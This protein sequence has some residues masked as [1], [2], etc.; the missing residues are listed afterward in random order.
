MKCSAE[1]LKASSGDLPAERRRHAGN[2]DEARTALPSLSVLIPCYNG[3]P[4]VVETVQSVVDQADDGVECVVVD[5]GST[6]GSADELERR[7]GR[8]VRVVRQP[9]GGPSAARNRA[10]AESQSELV[11][12]LD[13]DDHLAPDTL[14]ARRAA[15][16][17]NPQLELHFGQVEVVN[18]DTGE[19]ETTPRPPCDQSYMETAL[20]AHRNLPHLNGVTFRRTALERVGVFDPAFPIC[21]DYDLLIRACAVLCWKFVETVFSYRRVGSFESV[22]SRRGVLFNYQDVGK[23]L[24]KNRNLFRHALGSHRPWQVAYARWATDYSMHLLQHGHRRAACVWALR[25]CALARTKV[26]LRALKCLLEGAAP[27]SFYAALRDVYR[28]LYGSHYGRNENSGT[29]A[30]ASVGR[31]RTRPLPSNLLPVRVVGA[32]TP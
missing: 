15:F 23:V 28:R 32:R 18:I 19:R 26:E 16:V 14:A 13:A 25:A 30:H 31:R 8:A 7:F 5:D 1:G 22:T 9:N 10:L 12:W 24:I 21:Q 17:D 27:R 6:D 20:L 4:F 2:V 11:I 3:L 29:L